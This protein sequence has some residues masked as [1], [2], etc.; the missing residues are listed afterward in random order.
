MDADLYVLC[1]GHLKNVKQIFLSKLV[2][3]LNQRNEEFKD[4][5]QILKEGV[6]RLLTFS[7]SVNL[8]MAGW[9]GF[10]G[11]CEEETCRLSC[12]VF[13]NCPNVVMLKWDV[14]LGSLDVNLLGVFDFYS[15]SA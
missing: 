4:K 8:A 15:R 10:N 7:R 12:L 1:Q 6:E 2:R 14:D 13:L 11:I 5:V 3:D 9:A